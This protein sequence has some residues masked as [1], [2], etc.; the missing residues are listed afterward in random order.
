MW[1]RPLADPGG[2]PNIEP[3]YRED[4]EMQNDIETQ[5]MKTEPDEKPIW[6]TFARAGLII[7]AVLH[8]IE[9]NKPL[10]IPE[11]QSKLRPYCTVDGA[12]NLLGD[13][14][15]VLWVNLSPELVAA[16]IELVNNEQLYYW[17]VHWTVYRDL[18]ALLIMPST[19]VPGRDKISYWWLPIV[20]ATTPC[21]YKYW[22]ENGVPKV[23][24]AL[25]KI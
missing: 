2:R 18:D 14:G 21:P 10:T 22:G 13:N 25:G 1:V 9:F 12:C 20:L 17:P 3:F 5:D 8:V 7:K 19:F 24:L 16:I 11:L 6:I 15:D 23:C 4:K